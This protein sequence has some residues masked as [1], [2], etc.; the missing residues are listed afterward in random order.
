MSYWFW[1]AHQRSEIRHEVRTTI[2]ET[3][4]KTDLVLLKFST[5]ELISPH[6]KWKHS[7]EFWYQDQM[8]DIIDTEIKNDSIYYW[9]WEDNAEIS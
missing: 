5:A 8:Y 7:K 9:C 2:K 6:I 4:R 1:L 3:V